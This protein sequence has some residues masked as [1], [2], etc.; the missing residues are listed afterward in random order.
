VQLLK[1]QIISTNESVGPY[2]QKAEKGLGSWA[3][4]VLA[5]I[6]ISIIQYLVRFSGSIFVGLLINE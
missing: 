2:L 4:S 5:I 3:F 1:A 6:I